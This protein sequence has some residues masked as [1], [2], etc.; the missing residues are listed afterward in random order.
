MG[1]L[2]S[3]G[4]LEERGCGGVPQLYPPQPS[5][6]PRLGGANQAEEDT[7]YRDSLEVGLK[8][9]ITLRHL[10]TGDKYKSLMYLFYVPH[11][12]FSI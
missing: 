11:N 1:V 10:A 12:T 5:D 3:H 2:K 4:A 6:V 7:W 8:V 9:A